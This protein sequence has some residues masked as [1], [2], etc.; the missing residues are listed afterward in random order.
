[1]ASRGSGSCRGR[2]ARQKE[3][4]GGGRPRGGRPRGGRYGLPRPRVRRVVSRGVTDAVKD[5]LRLRVDDNHKEVRKTSA[6]NIATEESS[7]KRMGCNRIN[8]ELL[9]QTNNLSHEPRSF[10][11]TASPSY[12]MRVVTGGGIV[13]EMP[14]SCDLE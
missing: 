12:V 7:Q 8:F 3:D 9:L 10:E 1:M 4:V 11:A 5:H 13:S 6:E 14:N 2:D